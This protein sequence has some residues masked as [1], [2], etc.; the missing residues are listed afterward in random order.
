MRGIKKT[1]EDFIK[2]AQKIHENKYDY[3]KVNYQHSSKHITIICPIHGEFQQKPDEHLKGRGCPHCGK[4]HAKKSQDHFIEQCN[5]LYNN[6]Y[7]YSKVNYINNKTK[8]CI[9]CP[10]HGEFWKA[11]IKHLNACQGCPKCRD[12]KPQSTLEKPLTI[13]ERKS[14]FI[15][16]AKSTHKGK[17]DYG[18][19]VYIKSNIKIHIL[20]PIHGT[21]SMTPHHHLQGRGCPKCANK[22]V[23]QDDFI[24]KARHIHKDKYDYS[25]VIYVDAST[26][27]SI[28]C[29]KHGE[30]QQTPRIHV[31]GCNCPQ[32]AKEINVAETKL[33]ESILNTFPN[34]CWIHS[35][36][37]N[38]IL[39]RMELDIYNP[40][41]RIAIEYQ[42][43]QHFVD[44]E[45]FH[46]DFKTVYDRDLKKINI[47]Q[48]NNI[49]LFHFTYKAQDVI[50]EVEYPII[51][52]E[53][54]LIKEI[55]NYID[56][57]REN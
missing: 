53:N 48:N 47:C 50:N 15:E 52:N 5:K 22:L 37:N 54:E 29:P 57:K 46:S 21:F 20:C 8:V 16:K 49:K 41:Y 28:L 33:F 10:I 45:Y 32:C 25:K 9:I 36:R 17:Y 31:Q 40:E 4:V 12:S 35:Y 24:A 43:K 3:S 7:D 19:I 30:F 23:T 56:L 26:P 38:N 51:T 18:N 2:D 13:E 39:G 11:P 1:T 14:L 55:Q 34:L 44:S 27:I 42:G 6:K